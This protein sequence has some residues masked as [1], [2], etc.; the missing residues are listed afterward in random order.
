MDEKLAVN[1]TTE[2]QEAMAAKRASLRENIY[3]LEK[4]AEKKV[5]DTLDQVQHKVLA[6]TDQVTQ[7]VTRPV[8]AMQEKIEAVQSKIQ[9]IPQAL[10]TKP[11][12]TLLAVAIV[13]VSLGFLIGRR[14]RHRHHMTRALL[15]TR[16][17][18]PVAV[19]KTQ[20]V[21]DKKS[22][23]ARGF[24]ATVASEAAHQIFMN[25]LTSLIRRRS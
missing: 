24:F 4:E 16:A 23:L 15:E 13:G 22:K 18:R 1:N 11:A 20:K 14:G 3:H 7:Q 17:P 12:K 9:S 2:L 6:A 25:S 8:H 10:R 5:L 19:Q 21:L